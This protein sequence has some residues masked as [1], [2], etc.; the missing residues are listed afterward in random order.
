MIDIIVQPSHDWQMWVQPLMS[1]GVMA[2]ILVML[3][4]WQEN[5][6][7]VGYAKML[8]I[9]LREIRRIVMP[10]SMRG[11]EMP[12]AHP[13]E[14]LPRESYDSLLSSSGMAY[15]DTSIQSRLRRFYS[16]V[17]DHRYD[18]LRQHVDSL[19]M[20]VNRIADSRLTDPLARCLKRA[21]GT[22]R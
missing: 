12:T 8:S 13:W 18:R 7:R 21:F 15:F 6:R 16:D 2:F 4:L 14:R 3:Y 1:G 20:A 17:D 22:G 9:E 11:N 19:R 10:F 5:R